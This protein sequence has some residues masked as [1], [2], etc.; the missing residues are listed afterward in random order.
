MS[1]GTI[2]QVQLVLGYVAWLAWL[3]SYGLPWARTKAPEEVHR[4]IATL[5]GFRLFG[6]VFIVPGVV[7]SHLPDKF[8]TFAAY[9]DLAT[10]ILAISALI[11]F[12]VRPLFWTLVVAF[13]VAGVCDLIVDY[14][15]AIQLGLPEVAGELQAAYVIPIIYVP[16][17]MITHMIAFYG[18]FRQLRNRMPNDR[19][20]LGIQRER[21][22]IVP[23]IAE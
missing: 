7:G 2:F 20:K 22:A 6:L 16:L 9:G 12:G 13:N 3:V 21:S 10:G 15:H 4:A 18:L 11:S 5:H 8:A 19:A 1:I 17:L 14:Y 23:S